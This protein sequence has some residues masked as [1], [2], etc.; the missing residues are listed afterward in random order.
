VD[1]KQEPGVK[2]KSII[3]THG[4]E[5]SSMPLE[6]SHQSLH[7]A[8]RRRLE[9]RNFHMD[10]TISAESLGTIKDWLAKQP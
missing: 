4:F 9:C 1:S 5:D 6:W 7:P 3:M 8:L 2:A 10:H